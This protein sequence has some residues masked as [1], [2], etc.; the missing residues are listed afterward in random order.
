MPALGFALVPEEGVAR[1]SLAPRAVRC[2][3]P[4]GV[5]FVG[6]WGAPRAV[7][8][9]VPQGAHFVREWG[10]PRDVRGGVPQGVQLIREWGGFGGNK[11]VP[12]M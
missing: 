11:Q 1:L 5:Q 9:G 4:Q 12:V 6:E 10:A 7:R 8:C 3:V 2:G